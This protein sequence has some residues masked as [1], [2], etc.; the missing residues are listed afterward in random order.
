MSLGDNK[1]ESSLAIGQLCYFQPDFRKIKIA[2]HMATGNIRYL[3]DDSAI[4]VK[5]VGVCFT[6]SKVYYDIVVPTGDGAFYNASPLM[7]IDSVMVQDAGSRAPLETF[8]EQED[9]WWLQI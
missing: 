2:R 6:E 8:E 1:F 5:V 4:A 3:F 9:G 7:R